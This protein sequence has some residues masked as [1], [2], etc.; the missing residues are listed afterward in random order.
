[1]ANPTVGYATDLLVRAGAT[2]MFSE[3]TEVRD[4]IDQLTARAINADVA[5]GMIHEMAWYDDYLKKGGVDRSG[6]KTWA[7]H[8]KQHNA[9]TLFNPAPI[10]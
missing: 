3:T 10:T 7:E 9:L 6:K 5:N 4:G 1:M 8:W 2:M